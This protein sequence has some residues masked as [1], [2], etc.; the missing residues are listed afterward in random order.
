MII[1]VGEEIGVWSTI[2]LLIVDSILGAVLMRSQ[3][4]AAWR[5][6]NEALA[7]GPPAGARGARRRARHLRRRAAAHPGL[8]HRH[9]RP[10]SCCCR[11]RARSSARLLVRRFAGRMVVSRRRRARRA[12][13]AGRARDYD[14]EGTA[15]EVDRPARGCRD[16]R[17]R[18]RGAAGPAATARRRRDGRVRRPGRAALRPGARSASARRRRRAGWGCCST[19]E[20]SVGRRCADRRAC[21]IEVVEPL[22]ALARA[23]RRRASTS[24][25]RRSA[26]AALDRRRRRAA[27]GMAATSSS[28]A[29]AGRSRGGASVDCLGQRG[30]SW[31]APDWSKLALARTV[32][33][34]ST[35]GTAVDAHRGPVGVGQAPRRRGRSRRTSSST[36]TPRRRRR[37]AAQHDLRRRR[38]P[39]PRRASSCGSTRRG[40]AT[41]TAPPARCVCG[42]T[43][44]LGR[45]RLDCAFFAWRMEGRTGVGRYD[46]LRRAA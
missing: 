5:R 2:A 19:G 13:R 10:R 3:G 24:S 38:A 42:T 39:A 27:G 22:R 25:S 45:L 31:G 29:S 12:G 37:A 17:P 9:R 34:G 7:R 28:A 1:Q 20:P 44:D 23:L 16:G 15:T 36:A 41:R 6:F 21:A 33:A 43:L 11:R 4:R 46:V 32:S 26:A 40:R 8:R 30:H 18:A 14:V 35:T